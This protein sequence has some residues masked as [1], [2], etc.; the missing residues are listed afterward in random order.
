MSQSNES[1]ARK[2]ETDHT[3]EIIPFPEVGDFLKKDA[4]QPAPRTRLSRNFLYYKG[5]QIPILQFKKAGYGKLL[6]LLVREI[7]G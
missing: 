4:D 1:T 7:E 6:R 3:P 5:K 2:I